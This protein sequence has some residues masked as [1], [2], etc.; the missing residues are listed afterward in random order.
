MGIRVLVIEDDHAS[1]IIMKKLLSSLG[2]CVVAADG[3]KG[4]AEFRTALKE[5]RPYD[6]VCLDIMMPEMNGQEV[7]CE[8]R[9]IEGKRGVAGQEAVKVLMTTAL[10]DS[11][12]SV[13]S[14]A[15]GCDGYITKPINKDVLMS[16]I[17]KLGILRA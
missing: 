6:L 8:I 2:E 14:F 12:T 10:R 11:E 7:L 1:Q 16:E 9:E 4:L 5:G 17:R 3:V 13:H 15:S